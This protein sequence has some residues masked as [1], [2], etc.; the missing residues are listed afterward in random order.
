VTVPSDVGENAGVI[1]VES[2]EYD[3]NASAIQDS[4][5]QTVATQASESAIRDANI[6]QEAAKQ[7]K[8]TILDNIATDTLV[9]VQ[10]GEKAMG[11]EFAAMIHFGASKL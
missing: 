2:S 8:N 5:I 3:A 10:D 11:S 4:S 1:N 7:A 9:S 6:G